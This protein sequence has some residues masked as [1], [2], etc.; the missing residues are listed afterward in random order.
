MPGHHLQISLARENSAQPTFQRNSQTT[1]FV[2]GWVLYA[3]TLVYDM[4]LYDD[5]LQHWGTLDDEMLRAM[6]LVLDTGL[7]ARHWSRAQ[8]IDYMLD[9]SGMGCSDAEAE[10]EVD[11]YIA[12]PARALS[13]KIGALT[14]Q[15]LRRDAEQRLGSRFVIRDLHE[16]VLVSDACRSAC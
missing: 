15:K 13:Y 1:A 8:A 16:T 5:P 9:H 2:E 11:R 4:G 7:D 6:G 10:A 14:I 12:I 3:E